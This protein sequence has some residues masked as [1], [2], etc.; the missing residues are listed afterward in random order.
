MGWLWMGHSH[1]TRIKS[2]HPQPSDA[3]T[4]DPSSEMRAEGRHRA[5]DVAEVHVPRQP[6]STGHTYRHHWGDSR[7]SQFNVPQIPADTLPWFPMMR[8][9]THPWVVALQQ[10]EALTF[11]RDCFLQA[12]SCSLSH[13]PRLSM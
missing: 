11:L 10:R 9:W 3:S 13:Q 1:H 7:V 2:P 6:S 4:Q 5:K 8:H 12:F